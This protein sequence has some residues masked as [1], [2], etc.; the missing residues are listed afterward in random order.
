VIEKGGFDMDILLRDINPSVVK[1]ID[2]R[3]KKSN[4]SR[5]IYLKN[6]IENYV[7]INDLNEREM[8]LKNTLDKN[9]EMLFILGKQLKKN[10]EVLQLLFEE[11]ED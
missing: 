1:S 2:E 8:E 6:L 3:A 10:N 9:T 4:V 5:Q 11:D 7:M